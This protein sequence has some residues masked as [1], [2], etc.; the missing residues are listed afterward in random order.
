[1]YTAPFT[2]Y[3]DPA[4]LRNKLRPLSVFGDLA[5][6]KRDSKKIIVY[7]Y[8]F[9]RVYTNI[10]KCNGLVVYSFMDFLGDSVACVSF[11]TKIQ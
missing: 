4:I 8:V 9:Y 3:Y 1:M 11:G 10:P 2:Y 6:R 7:F 5:L